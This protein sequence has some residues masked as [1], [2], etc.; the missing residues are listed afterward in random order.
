M[1]LVTASKVE[2]I[3][4]LDIATMG[5]LGN[6]YRFNC[7]KLHKGWRTGKAPP[8]VQFYAFLEDLQLCVV[9]MNICQGVRNG[10]KHNQTQ[11]SMSHIKPHKEMYSSVIF[12]RIK[13]TVDLTG[14]AK[15]SFL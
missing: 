12:R 3:H 4:Q 6:R 15:A 2:K 11:L 10:E 8:T 7:G 1:A 14:G 13:D 5:K 9:W